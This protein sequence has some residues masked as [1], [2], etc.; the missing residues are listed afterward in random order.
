MAFRITKGHPNG[1]MFSW[2]R[3]VAVAVTG[4]KVLVVTLNEN[5][6]RTEW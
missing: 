4:F 1:E 5:Y 6:V 2:R 3:M